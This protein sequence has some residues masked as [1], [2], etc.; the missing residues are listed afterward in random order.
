MFADKTKTPLVVP[1]GSLAKSFQLNALSLP[2]AAGA[3][4]R[5]QRIPFILDHSVIQY[6]RDAL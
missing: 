5:L 6:E 2:A 3:R 1:T 4:H